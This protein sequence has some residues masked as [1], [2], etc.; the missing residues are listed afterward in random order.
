MSDTAKPPSVPKTS[1]G[2]PKLAK[3]EMSEEDKR[4]Q[5]K[6]ELII[7]R[8]S[9]SD[10]EVRKNA[11]Q[12][13]ETEL[14]DSSGS[15]VTSIPKP[16][17]LLKVHYPDLKA[18]FED[19]GDETLKK[20]FADIMSILAVTFAEDNTR[21]SLKYKLQGSDQLEKWGFEYIRALS[22]EI[23]DEFQHR[24]NVNPDISE[25]Q[26]M[27]LLI[28]VNR[29]V[30]YLK[31]TNHEPDACDLLIE[32]ERL[33]Q[34]VDF[35]DKDNYKRIALYLIQTSKYQVEPENI[36][37][38]KIVY[39]IYRK[40]ENLPQA[41]RMS[42]ILNRMDYVRETFKSSKD[43][44][45]TAQLAF[46][47]ARHNIILTDD[48]MED[49]DDDEAEY[50]IEEIMGNALLSEMYLHLAKEL[51]NLD[52]K[53][54]ED[55][56]KSHLEDTG[57]STR[58]LDSARQNLADTFVNAFA[59]AGFGTDK[60]MT[61]P[62]KEWVFKNKEHGMMSAAASLGMLFLWNTD[63]GL[64]QIDK[65]QYSGESFIKAGALMGI[66]IINSGIRSDV[67]F[68]LLQEYIN[69]DNQD[70]RI[71]AILGLGIAYAGSAN[72]DILEE[73]LPILADN[74][75]PID[76]VAFT[77]LALGQI[78]VGSC[79]EE[80][81]GTILQIMME[82]PE[83][84]LESTSVR[85]MSLALGL[86]FIGQQQSAD[87]IIESTKTLSK[88]VAQY[89]AQTIETCAYAGTGNVLKIQQ[90]L[91]TCGEHPKEDEQT[92]H[93]SVAVLGLAVVAMGESIGNEMLLRIF[94]HLLRFGNMTVKRA[95]P[96]AIA[97]LYVSNP[98]V[99]VM[100]TLGKLSH[101]SDDDIA[102]NAILA[103]GII[104]A[105][106]NNARIAKML[107][108]LAVYYA[109]NPSMLFIVRISQGILYAGKSMITL[110]PLYS[111]RLL[112]KPVAL[113]GLLIV[114]HASFDMKNTI[115][116]K[117]H[118]LLYELATSMRPRMMIAVDENLK[119]VPVSVRVGMAVDT[120][121]MAGKPKTITGFQTH[122]TPVVL[123][124]EER[125]ELA[126]HK[127]TTITDILE[128]VVVVK[129]N[130]NYVEEDAEKKK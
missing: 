105:G 10:R 53:S 80:V 30:P 115:L 35:A 116:S 49:E 129:K 34:I 114:L 120:V 119:P 122:D 18:K 26:Q 55:V 50:T 22:G 45:M 54:P 71:G 42:L 32:V 40:V 68:A 79:N 46:D 56:Y 90:L 15:T 63:E 37:T 19:E 5:A 27:D 108:Q 82:R 7:G 29:I 111:E 78:F 21:E 87:A 17:K 24:I 65:Y 36:E 43:R 66:G 9:D 124:S 62:E 1:K 52:P 84:V 112:V 113:A 77:A 57:S 107:R 118:F 59:N 109:K 70:M 81:T 31:R 127:Y 89:A 98:L 104:G 12:M 93:Q 13:L 126:S 25:E 51:D 48:D 6:L 130:P 20:Q 28:L 8:L 92:N 72:E 64:N 123:Q 75:Q 101:D 99:R 23:G 69:D 3:P 4:L 39:R 73:L 11:L 58:T 91:K 103:L 67:P 96:L 86:L 16:L 85:Y 61:D 76:V 60:L 38:L 95:V 41:M 117:F 47:L 44:L 97:L 121:G 33:D 125:A 110:S 106:T 14:T 83:K 88:P 100:D 2:G 102:Q 128:G 94:D 74:D